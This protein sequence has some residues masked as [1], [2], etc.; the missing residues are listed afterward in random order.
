MKDQT[1]PPSHAPPHYGMA[2]LRRDAPRTW[3]ARMP[4]PDSPPTRP[5]QHMY[6]A[7]DCVPPWP[8]QTPQIPRRARR[9]PAPTTQADTLARSPRKDTR[10]LA[11]RTDAQATTARY[12]PRCHAANTR[13]HDTRQPPSGRAPLTPRRTQGTSLN[14]HAPVQGVA[15]PPPRILRPT[16]TLGI[17]T[18]RNV[19]R[20]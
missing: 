18:P 3:A 8:S 1:P 11:S 14:T 9:E 19:I 6:T 2:P 15:E 20:W 4:D 10:G 13:M 7:P 5:S 12:R 17:V 16:H